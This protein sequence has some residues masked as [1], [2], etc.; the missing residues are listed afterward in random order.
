MCSLVVLTQQIVMVSP[1]T[2]TSVATVA[3]PPAPPAAAPL[4]EL[5]FAAAEFLGWEEWTGWVSAG[6]A[7]TGLP[8]HQLNNPGCIFYFH[9][10]NSVCGHW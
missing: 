5:L 4:P 1:E 6:R 7:A 10:S 9:F 3:I 8:F 2:P